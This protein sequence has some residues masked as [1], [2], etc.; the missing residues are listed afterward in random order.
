M[1]LKTMRFLSLLFT[2]IALG[3]GLAHLFAL[4]NKIHLPPEEYL[5]VQQIYRGWALLGIVLGM[6]LISTLVLT[7]MVRRKPKA[8][9][10]TLIALLCI[11]GSLLVFF[12]FTYP[13]N[14]RTENWTVLPDDW[15][16]LR[17]QW[18]YSHA[19]NAILY[20]IAL[21]VLIWSVLVADEPAV[22]R[23]DAAR[24]VHKD[25]EAIHG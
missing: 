20:V 5:T 23:H 9:V 17:S 19:A 11:A 6:A 7:L 3:A 14:Q 18:E 24:A 12:I 1:A 13:A 22:T 10:L 25:R 4:P 21:S 15:Q 2:A 8:F 16:Q